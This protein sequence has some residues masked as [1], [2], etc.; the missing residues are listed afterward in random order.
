LIE[1][2]LAVTGGMSREAAF[3]SLADKHL[4]SS[5]RLAA[6]ILGDPV[7]AQDAVHDAF[8]AAWRAWHS[9]R[10]PDRFEAWFGKI[11]VNTCRNRLKRVRRRNVVDISHEISRSPGD[12][13]A[14]AV[15]RR[16]ISDAFAVLTPDQQI[17]V[18]LRFYADLTIDEIAVRVGAPAGTV[19]SRLH[20]ATGRLRLE[21][22]TD[23][24]GITQ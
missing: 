2:K 14:G 8:V 18:V 1:R 17:V 5:Y 7:D 13:L 20:A 15:D 6:V 24:E 19:K 16:A 3:A 22:T 23:A 9:L 21:L 11:L 10:D 12:D 4:A